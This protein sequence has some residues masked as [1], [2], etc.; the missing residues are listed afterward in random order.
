MALEVPVC[1]GVSIT[2]LG[3]WRDCIPWWEPGKEETTLS[4]ARKQEEEE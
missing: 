1:D 2:T 4:S 3:F